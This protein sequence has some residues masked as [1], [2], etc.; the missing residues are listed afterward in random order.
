MSNLFV[1]T[2]IPVKNLDR[3]MKF[4]SGVLAIEMKKQDFPDF[5]LGMFPG[6]EKEMSGCLYVEKKDIKN[7][8]GPLLYF[9]ADG[10]LDDAEKKIKEYGGEILTTKHQ[11][12]E[13]GYRV[14]AKDSE[15]NRIAL[16][17]SKA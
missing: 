3:A 5:S 10:R 4:Y 15:G 17:S 12:G 2:D 14:V 16:H 11:I 9:N 6:G 13:Y 8:M 7:E 1:W